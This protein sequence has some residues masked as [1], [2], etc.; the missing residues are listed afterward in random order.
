MALEDKLSNYMLSGFADTRLNTAHL[1]WLIKLSST[2]HIDRL[3]KE[4]FYFYTTFRNQDT[5]AND[6]A[7]MGE[8]IMEELQHPDY[9]SLSKPP[10]PGTRIVFADD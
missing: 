10:P 9:A 3:L 7:W 1:A 6:V 2:S 4:F 8:R 5:Y